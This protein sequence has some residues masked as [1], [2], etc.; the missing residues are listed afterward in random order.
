MMRPREV[1]MLSHTVFTLHSYQYCGK[2]EVE[3]SPE[4]VRVAARRR[5]SDGYGH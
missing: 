4:D 1:T 3:A 2:L 5:S